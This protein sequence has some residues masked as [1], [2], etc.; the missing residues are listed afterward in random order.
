MQPNRSNPAELYRPIDP[1]V[2]SLSYRRTLSN[3]LR[4][5]GIGNVD[6]VPL[7][8]L[9]AVVHHNH[10]GPRSSSRSRHYQQQAL[11]PIA[12]ER[13]TITEPRHQHSQTIVQIYQHSENSILNLPPVHSENIYAQPSNHQRT[14]LLA[15]GH[16]LLVENSLVPLPPSLPN[17]EQS[18]GGYF[19]PGSSSNSTS[20]VAQNIIVLNS[21]GSRGRSQSRYQGLPSY[22]HSSR[23][24]R[25]PSPTAS[26]TRSRSCSNSSNDRL[27][28]YSPRSSS[29]FGSPPDVETGTSAG[30]NG[31]GSQAD[32]V[33]HFPFPDH[34]EAFTSTVLRQIYLHTLLRLPYLYFSRVDRIFL[35]VKLTLPEIKHMALEAGAAEALGGQTIYNLDCHLTPSYQNLK[36]TWEN[37]IDNLVKEWKITNVISALV[38]AYVTRSS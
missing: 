19:P 8:S 32:I 2:P 24:S 5:S 11:Q 17:G 25:C 18:R 28:G 31:T 22:S 10:P 1:F 30:P 34:I 15:L 21:E 37:F 13:P 9:A 12:S 20:Q 27:L 35:Q 4:S 26:S 29:P 33:E 14:G 16:G 7:P 38:L 36:E 23:S 6:D 3:A